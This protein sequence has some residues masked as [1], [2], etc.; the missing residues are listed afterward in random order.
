MDF[1]KDDTNEEKAYIGQ[2]YNSLTTLSHN[3]KAIKK[4]ISHFY[5]KIYIKSIARIN[6]IC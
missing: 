4:I 6:L 5:C 2:P 1:I 3:I